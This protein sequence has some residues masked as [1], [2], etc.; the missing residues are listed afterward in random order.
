MVPSE[1]LPR[2][3]RPTPTSSSIRCAPDGVGAGGELRVRRERDLLEAQ[4]LRRHD[5]DARVPP[6]ARQQLR[7]ASSRRRRP[8]PTA[9]D[10]PTSA[11][12]MLWQNASATTCPT[13]TPRPARRRAV[14]TRCAAAPDGRRPGPGLAVGGEVA[15][16]GER[17]DGGVH[18]GD[19]ERLAGPQD[20]P[21][22]QGV[23][24]RGGVGDP[25]G[26]AAAQRGEARVEALGRRRARR[27]TT[28]AG[29]HAGQPGHQRLPRC[30]A[31]AG[32]AAAAQPP[33]S[34]S[35]CATWPRAC[36][37]ESVRPATVSRGVGRPS[38]SLRSTRASPSS[39]APS[40]VR[41]PG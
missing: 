7:A 26:V 6:P 4:P 40:T 25:V 39:S 30:A 21:A 33:A 41:R 34:M 35:T 37:P 36:T 22:A 14:P 5:E 15:H 1:S 12:T 27:T 11:R 23:A 19:V 16:P 32:P 2:L 18:R 17:A 9:I 8:S 31:G 24:Q 38:C 10:A 13:T 29:Q 28:S 3:C 20:V